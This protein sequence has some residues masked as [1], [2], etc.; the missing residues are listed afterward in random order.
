[1]VKL[2]NGERPDFIVNPDVLK[3][4]RAPG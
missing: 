3:G 4:W 1:V 2:L